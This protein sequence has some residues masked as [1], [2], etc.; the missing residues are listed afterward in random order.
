M[1]KYSEWSPAVEAR[2]NELL[3]KYKSS[4]AY[5]K[6]CEKMLAADSTF[7]GPYEQEKNKK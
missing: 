2:S 1:A 7:V 4:G 6:D 3:E 5:A